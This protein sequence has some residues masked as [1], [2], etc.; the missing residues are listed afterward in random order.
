MPNNETVVQAD[1][2]ETLKAVLNYFY[3]ENT[4][5]GAHSRY[6]LKY[7]LVWITKYRRSFL[8]GELPKD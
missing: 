1:R 5:S 2:T 4:K 3:Q 6:D 8:V 7:H